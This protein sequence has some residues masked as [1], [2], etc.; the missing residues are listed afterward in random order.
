MQAWSLASLTQLPWGS[1]AF[2]TSCDSLGI[3]IKCWSC[4]WA[5][6]TPPQYQAVLG[7]EWIGERDLEYWRVR[8]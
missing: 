8:G 4:T 2:P 5:E 7:D 6:A 1:F 3:K